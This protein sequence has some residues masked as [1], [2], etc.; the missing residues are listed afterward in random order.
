MKF[1]VA[2]LL[3]SGI[4]GQNV[5]AYGEKEYTIPGAFCAYGQPYKIFVRK[6]RSDQLLVNMPGGGACWNDS[7]CDPDWFQYANTSISST[8][9]SRY[10]GLFRS[11]NKF[12]PF[13]E[14]TVVTLPY[15]TGDLFAGN[16]IAIY[17]NDQVN[18][19]GRKNVLLALNFLLKHKIVV[20]TQIKQL[21][22]YGDSAG[23]I[24]SL[25]NMDLFEQLGNHASR[26]TAI[27]DS[28]GLH[29]KN[30]VWD[31]FSQAYVNNLK[32]AGQKV[33]FPIKENIGLQA[34]QLGS[35]CK[36][37]KTWNIGILQGSKDVVMSYVFG[38]MTA[39]EHEDL[40]Y[41]KYGILKTLASPTDNCAVWVAQ[42]GTHV[43]LTK[44][45]AYQTRNRAGKSASTFAREV[46]SR[47]ASQR[48]P[49]S[50]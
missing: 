43:F 39:S 50:Y 23:G 44:N 18:H 3:V 46:L 28:P 5:F 20:R 35:L 29:W 26:K 1:T 41:S 30:N 42:T 49:S 7:S 34:A 37:Y 27:I 36:K 13:N 4:C 6:G 33:N 9:M 11:N 16:H 14:D 10:Q 47:K 12:S 24:G 40:I 21:S 48:M 31:R 2:I 19:T 15:C 25:L 38:R 8:Y 32:T 17:D 45:D 22:V